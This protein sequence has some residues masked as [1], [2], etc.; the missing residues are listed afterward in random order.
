[1]ASRAFRHQPS[2]M[3]RKGG[4]LIK[5]TYRGLFC[6]SY[7]RNTWLG[8]ETRADNGN[9]AYANE[10][11]VLLWT[12][13]W[14]HQAVVLKIAFRGRGRECWMVAGPGFEPKMPLWRRLRDITTL[15]TWEAGHL[16]FF[17][18]DLDRR[19]RT[20]KNREKPQS[21]QGVLGAVHSVEY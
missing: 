5:S 8:H 7:A 10:F 2:K 3:P 21:R 6:H 17:I 12:L 4:D 15:R 11:T 20:E 9:C 13:P 18:A 19:P 16:L 14:P 1:M